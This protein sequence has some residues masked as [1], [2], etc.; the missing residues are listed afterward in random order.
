MA[1]IK[2]AYKHFISYTSIME[3][4]KKNIDNVISLDITQLNSKITIHKAKLI[5]DSCGYIFDSLVLRE[6]AIGSV[7]RIFFTLNSP[8]LN[9]WSHDAP[10]VSIMDIKEQMCLGEILDLEKIDECNRYPLACGERIWFN[11]D[12]IIEIPLKQQSKNKEKKMK[13]LLTKQY[14]TVTGPL[15]TIEHIETLYNSDSDSS[16]GSVDSY[17]D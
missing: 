8:H 9:L 12:C 14:V 5:T 16:N 17:S 1:K 2:Q 4:S 13:T 11:R 6:L 7:V 10:Y 15:Y 3:D